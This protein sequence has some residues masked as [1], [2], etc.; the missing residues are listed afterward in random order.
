MSAPIK[1]SAELYDYLVAL[2]E[3][4]L[5]DIPTYRAPVPLCFS[6]YPP[7][8][9]DIVCCLKDLKAH[10]EH[11]SYIAVYRA[12]AGWQTVWM[13]WDHECAM[14][15]PAQTGLGPYGHSREGYKRACAE[16]KMWAKDE[17]VDD[18]IEVRIAPFETYRDYKNRTD[19]LLK[20]IAKGI[21]HGEQAGQKE[22]SDQKPAV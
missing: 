5:P 4:H 18:D 17:S 11:P 3:D 22:K 7:H 6:H 19:E 16:A 2:L 12:I 21:P 8:K 13:T 14:H 9:E 20:N 1:V 15:A 10:Q